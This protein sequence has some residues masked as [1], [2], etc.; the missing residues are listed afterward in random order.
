MI[1][2]GPHRLAVKL[3]QEKRFSLREDEFYPSHQAI[4]FY[5][6]YK[7]DIALMAEMGF[8]V[9][10]TSIAWS[11]IYPNG[12]ETTPNAEGVAFYRDLFNECKKYNIE[13]LVTLCHFD[14][15]MYLVAEYGSWRNRKMVE[16]FTRYAR[17]CFEEFD[18]LV[19][20][21]LTFNE[22]NILLHSPFSGAGLVFEPHE[23]QDQVKYQAAHHELL[24]SALATKI[25]HEINPENQVGCMLAGGISIHG[26]VNR[27]MSGLR[28]K[29]TVK[30]CFLLMFKLGALI[31]LTP[32]DFSGRKAFLLPL[33]QGMTISSNIPWI[34]SLLATMPLVVH[35]RT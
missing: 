28:C 15:P 12:D 7:D 3:G 16:F 13:P 26:L 19:K 30:I 11:R 9:F 35:L 32:N 33:K 21:W 5:H 29:K 23:N 18:G 10:R 34:L 4:D 14:V 27:K 31:Q 22:I 6:R 1:P 20:Y 17:T 8:T 25:A 24:A 2:H